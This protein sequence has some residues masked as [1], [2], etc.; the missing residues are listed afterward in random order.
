MNTFAQ[1]PQM[2][3]AI[4]HQTMQDRRDDAGR[5]AFARTVRAER[6]AR[7]HFI[8]ESRRLSGAP[9]TIPLPTWAFRFVHPIF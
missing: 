6:R 2:A 9:S 8:R 4:A 3:L 1:S 7:H 5:R